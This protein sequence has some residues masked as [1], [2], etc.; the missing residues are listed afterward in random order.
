MS[1]TNEKGRKE[2]R[3]F[4]V[5]KVQKLG[6]TSL[7][8]TLPKKWVTSWGIKP[9]DKIFIEMMND[10]SLRLVSEKSRQGGERKLIVVNLDSLKLDV[11]HVIRSLY[12]LGFDEVILETDKKESLDRLRATVMNEAEKYFG[13][14]VT[15]G[16]G[17]VIRLEYVVD[18]EKLSNE[19]L[20]KRLMGIVSRKI[21]EIQAILN[22]KEVT[23]HVSPYEIERVYHLLLRKILK[24]D[25]SVR[26]TIKNYLTLLILTQIREIFYEL[27]SLK[28]SI[29]K[30]NLDDK[31]KAVL[32]TIINKY[33][34]IQD[35]VIMG[36]LLSSVKKINVGLSALSEIESYLT[37]IPQE[38]SVDLKK[39][40]E[41]FYESLSNSINILLL[42]KLIFNLENDSNHLNV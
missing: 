22:S 32:S 31:Q 13:L 1:V 41:L 26:T 3:G 15:E 14:E 29:T 38:V 9:G 25:L 16:N 27:E 42:E 23:E 11:V 4:E 20:L 19:S 24:G 17:G 6:S 7:F 35:V 34:D 28:N 36:V 18:D 40:N 30:T 8:I 10:G 39:I 37:T 33:N 5:R 12:D 2:E 21:D